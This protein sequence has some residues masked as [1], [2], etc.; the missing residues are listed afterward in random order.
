MRNS[1]KTQRSE[2]KQLEL[3]Y[4]SLNTYMEVRAVGVACTFVKVKVFFHEALQLRLDVNELRPAEGVLAHGHAG[5]TQETQ[6][7]EFLGKQKQQGLPTA[8]KAPCSAAD[9]VYVLSG[10]I[11]GIDLQNPVHLRQMQRPSER[12]QGH[13]R[14]A[15]NKR[16]GRKLP[17]DAPS[18]CPARALRRPCKEALH[19][20]CMMEA[21]NKTL[22]F[23]LRSGVETRCIPWPPNAAPI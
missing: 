15:L 6:K 3:D 18:E 7:A 8:A 21:E 1:L 16:R 19:S 17:L 20:A 14:I 13:L 11:G 12:S 5:L 23:V 4:S 10:V 22:L 2:L 9:A